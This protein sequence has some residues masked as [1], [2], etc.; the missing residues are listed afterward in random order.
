[1]IAA[2]GKTADARYLFE[3]HPDTLPVPPAPIIEQLPMLGMPTSTRMPTADELQSMDTD[4][5]IWMCINL[6]GCIQKAD[7]ALTDILKIAIWTQTQ[8][9]LAAMHNVQL[10]EALHDK[11]TEKK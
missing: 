2:V 9:R 8:L 11:K 7:E 10:N 6:S 3:T 5:L 4:E 1:M